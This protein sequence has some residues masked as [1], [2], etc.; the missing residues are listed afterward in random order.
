[1][2]QDYLTFKSKKEDNF[3]GL[4]PEGLELININNEAFFVVI[5]NEVSGDLS[6]FKITDSF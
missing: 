5:A 4:G 6:F 1:M 2:F 3:Y